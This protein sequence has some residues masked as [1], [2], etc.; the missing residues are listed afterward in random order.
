MK[1]L[2]VV[3]AFALALSGPAL[4]AQQG[5][6]GGPYK[7]LKSGTGRRR[8]RDRLHLRRRRRA[9]AVHPAQRFARRGGHRPPRRRRPAVLGR[10]T[11]FNLETLDPLGEIPE[12]RRPGRGRRSKIRA[13]VLEQQAG[14]DVRHEVA[15]ADQEDR[16]RRGARP[17]GIIFD[18]FNDRVYVFSH[19]TKDA[20]VI[21]ARDGTVVGTDRPGRRSRGSGDRRQGNAVRGDAGRRRGASPWSTR[22]R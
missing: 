8:R 18:P 3:S 14:L 16:R 9:A 6:S 1:R 11:V 19:P 22:R 15:D 7:V 5:G 10:I 21:D 2:A 20:T 17:D 12:H 4:V 13:R